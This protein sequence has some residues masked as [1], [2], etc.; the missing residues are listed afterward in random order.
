MKAESSRVWKINYKSLCEE[1]TLML[2]A[3]SLPGECRRSHRLMAVRA[4]S[5]S[6]SSWG[7]AEDSLANNTFLNLL[8]FFS[9]LLVPGAP[10]PPSHIFV[11][12]F[13]PWETFMFRLLKTNV[14]VRQRRWRW[15]GGE[16]NGFR[17]EKWKRTRWTVRRAAEG[18]GTISEN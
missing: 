12:A 4:T 18:G 8:A 16:S 3:N 9:S 14:T 10:P 13:F 7:E 1:I 5:L 2:S 11:A 6:V 15:V 17:G